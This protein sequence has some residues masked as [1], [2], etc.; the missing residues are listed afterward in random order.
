MTE[1]THCELL[2]T[3]TGAAD[4][5]PLDAADP[6]PQPGSYR[7]NASLLVNGH[8]LIDGGQ[9]ILASLAALGRRAQDITDLLITHSHSDHYYPPQV[10]A[11]AD[12]PRPMPLELW[13]PARAYLNLDSYAGIALHPLLPGDQAE[14]SDC[15]ALALAAN[16]LVEAS[17]ETALIYLFQGNNWRWLYA[18][19][20][21]WFTAH[22][23]R[24]LCAE[25]PLDALIIDAT[26]G[27]VTNDRRVFEHNSL[28]MVRQ[29]LAV[30][31][32][33]GMLKPTAQVF[34]TH[35]ARETHLPPAVLAQQD[36]A[37]GWRTALDGMA[38]QLP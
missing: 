36:K 4:W 38:V 15:S 10:R 6:F 27:D 29:I 35:L 24:R 20:G 22:T 13:Y 23:W 26:L 17:N 28:A 14:L 31:R 32:C 30:M 9:D 19:D 34:L 2:F 16:H 8:I 11:L 7:R 3:G 25:P 33:Y 21:A 1:P 12:L 37:E 5:P 18:T